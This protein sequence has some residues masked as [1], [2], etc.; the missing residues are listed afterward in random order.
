M[1]DSPPVIADLH[2]DTV[3]LM[4]QGYDISVRNAT[5]HIDIPRMRQAGVNL[6]CFACFV[7]SELPAGKRAAEV[8]DKIDTLESAC[9]KHTDQIAICRTEAEAREIIDSGRIAAFIAIE[10]GMALEDDLA[11]LEHFYSRG[12]RYMTLIHGV[13]SEWCVSDAD[14]EPPFDGLTEFGLEVV[15]RMNEL[16]MMIDVSHVHPLAIDKILANTR[17][18]I[19]ASHSACK[20]LCG[21]HRNLSDEH[22][23]GIA[24]ADGIIGMVYHGDFIS[25]KRRR[26][27]E[28]YIAADP[29]MYK[30]ASYFYFGKYTGKEREEKERTLGPYL[31][32]WERRVWPVN[33]GIREVI[34]HIDYIVRLVGPD[35]V[36]FGSDFDGMFLPPN[37]LED[38]SRTADIIKGL[39]E[40]GYTEDYVRLIQGENFMRVFRE[41][42]K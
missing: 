27:T 24:S 35:Y 40:Q 23:K 22:I 18:P 10:N 6:Q 31:A 41:V 14:K 5:G 4:R 38:I 9:K 13:T 1:S 7:D 32:E 3:M 33:P 29:E 16:G 8:D 21:H 19:I 25:D 34:D 37:G 15:R 12:V 17:A 2:C 28:A 42:C 20:A 30:D 36:G 11:K 26:I 39:S